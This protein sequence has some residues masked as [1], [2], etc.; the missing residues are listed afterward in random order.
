MKFNYQARSKRGEVQSGSIEASSREA[1]LSLLQRHNLFVTFLEETTARPFY[2][3]KIKLFDRI[4]KKELVNFSRQLSLMF[5]SKIPLVQA[6]QSIAEQTKNSSL[7]EKILSISQEVEGGT[8]FSQALAF[9]PKLFSTFYVSMVKSGE[10]SGTLSESLTYLADHLEREYHLQSKIQGAMIYP[11]LIVV[12]VIG[13]LVMMMYFV[14]PSMTRV[15]TETGQEL[16]FIT[17]I[18]ISL[19]NFIRGWGWLAFLVLLGGL[20]VLFRYSKTVEGKRIKDKFILQLPVIGSFLKMIYIS[21]FAENLSTLVKGGLPISQCLEITSEVVGNDVYKDIVLHV[22]EE[23][24]RGEKISKTLTQYP[25]EFPPILVQMVTVGEKT[26]TL[27]Q[28]LMNV[29]GFYRQEVE[30]SIDNLLS[31][32][33]PVMVVFL[34]GVVAGLMASILLPLYRMTGF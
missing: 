6:L 26:G 28:S 17:K 12:V 23:V 13:V 1:A 20:I 9:H 19:S 14:I 32:L 29:V 22:K 24:S 4:P 11:A 7:R 8:H 30:R 10:A 21:R 31:V 2:A 34:G 3:R 5:K 33:E 15:L 16:P 27:D 18:V 25:E